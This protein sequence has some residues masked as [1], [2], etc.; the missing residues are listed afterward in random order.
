MKRDLCLTAMVGYS[1][2]IIVHACNSKLVTDQSSSYT[3]AAYFHYQRHAILPEQSSV[4]QL[5]R[6]SV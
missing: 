6:C 2:L 3:L 5:Y 4:I 1:M